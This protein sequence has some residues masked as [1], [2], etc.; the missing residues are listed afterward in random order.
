MIECFHA[1]PI[2]VA[3]GLPTVTTTLKEELYGC[4]VH[5]YETC[6]PELWQLTKPSTTLATKHTITFAQVP[7]TDIRQSKGACAV[8]L[9]SQRTSCT[10]AQRSFVCSDPEALKQHHKCNVDAVLARNLNLRLEEVP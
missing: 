6:D 9:Q 1:C 2:N 5:A 10:L 7:A 3:L 4:Q 8:T